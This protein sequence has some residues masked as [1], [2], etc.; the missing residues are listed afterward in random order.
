[1]A[2]A[3]CSFNNINDQ[4]NDFFAN[5]IKEKYPAYKDQQWIRAPYMFNI[6]RNILYS[7]F[8]GGRMDPGKAREVAA[9][10]ARMERN[11]LRTTRLIGPDDGRLR[12]LNLFKRDYEKLLNNIKPQVNSTTTSTL[13]QRLFGAANEHPGEIA[14]SVGPVYRYHP[15]YDRVMALTGLVADEDN[16]TSMWSTAAAV[17]GR[18]E[19]AMSFSSPYTFTMAPAG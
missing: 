16:P 19:E 2:I 3:T 6:A 5:G 4:F 18:W 14:D 13:G 1:M 9:V 15:V 12:Y 17:N 8:A 7:T 10:Q 11:A